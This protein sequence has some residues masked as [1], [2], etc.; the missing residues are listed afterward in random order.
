MQLFQRLQAEHLTLQSHV[1]Y[2]YS[3]G[4]IFHLYTSVDADWN[5][6]DILSTHI[7]QTIVWLGGVGTLVYI[8]A[9]GTELQLAIYVAQ[10]DVTI[11]H[12]EMNVI[13]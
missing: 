6:T 12:C 11:T 5:I 9:S 3:K 4:L 1:V 13:L 2:R 7:L 8:P 10:L